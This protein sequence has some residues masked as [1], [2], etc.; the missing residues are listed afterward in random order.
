MSTLVD[1]V[2]N[3]SAQVRS[4]QAFDAMV[5]KNNLLRT[6]WNRW[7]KGFKTIDPKTNKEVTVRPRTGP[8]PET[9]FLF[10]DKGEAQKMAG[11]VATDFK[12]IV[13]P[14]ADAGRVI[15]R[16]VDTNLPLKGVD[17]IEKARIADLTEAG[18][19]ISNPLAGKF[20]LKEV[21][22]TFMKTEEAS[23]SLAA[24]IYN[25]L[26]LYPKGTSQMAK[27]VLAPF[28]HARN[29]LSATSFAAANGHL[30]FGNIDDVK[31]AWNSLQAPGPLG[32]KKSNEFYQEL[33]RLGVVNSNVRLKQV[34]DLLQDANFG[35]ILNNVNSDWALNKLMKRF[36]KIKK[37]A[38]DFYTA[39][40]D[41][42]KIFTF[43]GEK[44][45]ITNAYKNAGLR[46]GQEFTDINGVKRLF[47]D[48]TINELSADLVRNTVPNYSYVSDFIKGLRKLPLG[49][50]IAFP[51]EILRTGVNIVDTALKEINYSTLINDK[52]VRPLAGRGRQRLMGMAITTTAIPLGIGAAT[53]TIYD[54][55]EDEVNAMKRYVADWSKNS[56]LIPFKKDDGTLKVIEI[57]TLKE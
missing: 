33:L 19:K 17:D 10:E 22:D 26:V 30:P 12:E 37:G 45:K 4:G 56:V 57:L 18:Q 6:A 7:D 52:V 36:N 49:N 2:S 3:L 42:W 5:I 13:P 39:E 38:E 55:T 9:P 29:F 24:Q 43:L 28:T 1:G 44:T 25:N 16:F 48:R 41:F 23:K 31:K 54:I 27:T 11:G 35:S 53:K 32:F 40:D 34:M 14:Q 47:N 8:E 15:D 50:F 46:L 20:A 21:A 51:A